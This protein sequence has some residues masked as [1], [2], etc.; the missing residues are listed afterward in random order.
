MRNSVLKYV[1]QKWP[2][3]YFCKATLPKFQSKSTYKMVVITL[4][5]L[6][7]YGG[8][9]EETN[10]WSQF[11]FMHH[12]MTLCH[13]SKNRFI[14]GTS[15]SLKCIISFYCTKIGDLI[16]RLSIKFY[17]IKWYLNIFLI[18]KVEIRDKRFHVCALYM[19]HRFSSISFNLF[20][21]KQFSFNKVLSFRMFFYLSVF[22]YAFFAKKSLH[23]LYPFNFIKRRWYSR[24]L[25][26]I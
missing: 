23:M 7:N 8:W 14:T 2:K 19:F 17:S 26:W 10:H 18:P 3:G 1:V 20:P 4:S 21:P 6:F 25:Q 13:K 24:R 11:K 9:C 16:R 12:L 5:I 22:S 15:Y